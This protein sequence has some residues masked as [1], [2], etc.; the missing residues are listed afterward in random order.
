MLGK[1]FGIILG[2]VLILGAAGSAGAEDWCSRHIRYERHELNEAVRHHGYY[3]WQA[4]HERRE[5]DRLR[6]QCYVR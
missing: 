6:N 3:S 4:N 1:L 2:A 5:V